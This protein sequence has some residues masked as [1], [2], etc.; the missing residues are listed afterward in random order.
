MTNFSKKISS[1]LQLKKNNNGGFSLVECIIFIVII[2]IALTAMMLSFQTIGKN[3]LDSNN[4]TLAI[5]LAQER[6]DLL[7]K[8]AQINGIN[9]TNPCTLTSPPA[10]CSSPTGSIF[11]VS[12]TISNTTIS[13]DSNYKIITVTVSKTSGNST[14]LT[15][16]ALIG[17]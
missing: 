14:V 5:G 9:F 1:T 3:S 2:G 15:L 11:T 16:A 12:Q 10:I 6:M 13:G 8:Q 17:S 7:L 4:Q